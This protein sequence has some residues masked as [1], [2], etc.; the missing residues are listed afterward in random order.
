MSAQAQVAVVEWDEGL[1][2][3]KE[4]APGRRWPFDAVIDAIHGELRRRL[5]SQFTVAELASEYATAADWFLQVALDVAPSHPATHDGAITLD[6]A[7]GQFKRRAQDA[8]LW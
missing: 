6:A 1:R 4:I 5:G 3:L 8:A 7:F 2:R